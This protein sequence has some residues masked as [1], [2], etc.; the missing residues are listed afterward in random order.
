MPGGR[1][2]FHLGPWSQW[3]QLFLP[4]VFVLLSEIRKFVTHVNREIWAARYKVY[5]LLEKE[6]LLTD[7]RKIC[8]IFAWQSQCT[9]D[10][11]KLCICMYNFLVH[12]EVISS[13]YPC[14]QTCN[15]EPIVQFSPLIAIQYKSFSPLL[16][17]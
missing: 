12:N 6:K 7:I 4:L 1:S 10:Y 15:L 13:L 2:V 8:S 14:L 11:K 5:L 17:L 16:R 3:L 9:L